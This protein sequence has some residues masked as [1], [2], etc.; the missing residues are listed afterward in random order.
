MFDSKIFVGANLLI[1]AALVNLKPSVVDC[2]GNSSLDLT[3]S[4]YPFMGMGGF[5]MMGLLNPYFNSLLGSTT[6]V[7]ADPVAVDIVT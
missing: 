4:Y 3:S 7:T 1:A 2:F 5:G 6:S